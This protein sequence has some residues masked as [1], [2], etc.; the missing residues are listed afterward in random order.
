MA[1]CEWGPPEFDADQSRWALL[2][3]AARR[4]LAFENRRGTAVVLVL[5]VAW[6]WVQLGTFVVGW[7]SDRALW[8]FT[9]ESFP[10]FSPGLVLDTTRA[11][12]SA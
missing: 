10:R 8:L 7:G 11:L 2:A 5:I 9:T 6:Y 4:R 12:Y 3:V 1:G